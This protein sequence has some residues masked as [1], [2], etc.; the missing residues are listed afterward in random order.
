[1]LGVGVVEDGVSPVEERLK[2]KTVASWRMKRGLV[3]RRI[4][5]IRKITKSMRIIKLRIAANMRRMSWRRSSPWKSHSLVMVVEILYDDFAFV[6]CMYLEW[7]EVLLC[8]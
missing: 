2:A 1:M 4:I 7:K 3:G 6:F 5:Q 8:L